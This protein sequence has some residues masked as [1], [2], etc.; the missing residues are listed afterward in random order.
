MK[1]DGRTLVLGIGNVLLG[2]EG[3]GVAV[4]DHLQAEGGLPSHVDLLDGGTGSLVL[5]EP[6]R[7]A[8]RMI[9]I[10]ATADGQPPGT[11]QRLEP[12]FSTEYPV[13]LTAHDIGLRDLLDS[14]YL[15]GEEPE[16]VLFAVSIG[17]PQDMRYSLSPEVAAAL[18]AI[19]AAVRQECLRP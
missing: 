7:E 18:P 9:L 15:L 5:L 8:R 1:I 4:I 17:W 6:M 3:V 2:D 16:V 13:T 10:D 11:V 19:A 12:R 14:F